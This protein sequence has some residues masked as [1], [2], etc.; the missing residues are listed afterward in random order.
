MST[1]GE[2]SN[3]LLMNYKEAE[4]RFYGK[5][6]DARIDLWILIPVLILVAFS[7]GVVYS[8]SSSWSAK[9]NGDSSYLFKNH[10]LRAALGVFL[11]FL[12][13]RIDYRNLMAVRKL[14]IIIA[15]GLLLYLVFSK[16]IIKG[17]SRW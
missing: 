12:F 11:I 13:S 10:L 3:V 15:L 1:G 2:N 14:L 4:S 8:A 5:K 17:A 6:G 7:L 9:M 16:M